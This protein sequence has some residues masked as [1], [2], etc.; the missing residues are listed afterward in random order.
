MQSTRAAI[1][2]SAIF[3]M[4]GTLTFPTVVIARGGGGGFR[5]GGG[6][7]GGGERFGGGEGFGGG[8]SFGGGGRYGAGVGYGDGGGYGDGRGRSG[9]GYGGAYGN[10]ASGR[11][12]NPVVATP[13]VSE[14]D[15]RAGASTDYNWGSSRTLSS[16]G[17]FGKLAAAGVNGSSSVARS[18]QRVSPAALADVGTAVRSSYAYPGVFDHNFWTAHRDADWADAALWGDGWAWGYGDWS[19]IAGWWG[20]PVNV[21]PQD[22]DYGNNITYQ[23]DNVYYGSQPVESASAYYNQAQSLAASGSVTPAQ[24][25]QKSDWKPLGIFSMVQG[26]QKNTTDMFQLAVDKKGDIKGTYYNALTQETKAVQG[27]VDKKN[28]RASW[29][30]G[31]NKTIVYDTGFNNLLQPQSSMLV[32]YGKDKTQQ[33]TLVRLQQSH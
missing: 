15:L 33:W 22:Y 32:H 20:M 31:G 12:D 23:G 7:F 3:L 21:V 19:D 1:I 28:M 6:G 5:G 9:Y 17:G 25:N 2:C 29:I 27:A 13:R 24:A 14:Q 18:T 16:D 4:V 10:Q 11:T 26:S 8:E 30:V